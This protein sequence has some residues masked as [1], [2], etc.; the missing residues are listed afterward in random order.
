[1]IKRLWSGTTKIRTVQCEQQ[2]SMVEGIAS[3]H[4]EECFKELVLNNETNEKL[5]SPFMSILGMNGL[6]FLSCNK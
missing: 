3:T 4:Q 2:L 5:T 1:M 6:F